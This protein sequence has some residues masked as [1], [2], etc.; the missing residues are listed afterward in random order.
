MKRSWSALVLAALI[1]TACSPT[2]SVGDPATTPAP[3]PTAPLPPTPTSV[4]ATPPPAIELVTFTT[5]D[6]VRLAATLYN[7][8]DIAV[9][10]AHQG[11][12]GA[13]Q[14]TW[15]PFAEYIAEKGFTALTLD[16]RGRGQSGGALQTNALIL[17]V[18]AAIQFLHERGYQRIVCIGDSMGGS[19]C[20]R[21]AVENDLAG[22]VVIA[23]PMS[24]GRPTDTQPADLAKLTLPKLFVCGEKDRFEF[25][26]E[27]VKQM[28]ELSP[29]PKQ[30]K[31]YEGAPGH[32]TELFSSTIGDEF[33]DLLVSFLE[34]LRTGQ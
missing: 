20:L 16:F 15:Q 34:G 13:D 22:L 32:G 5:R 26:L 21:A 11:T 23:S 4:P 3:T 7:A 18:N 2:P 10:L 1:A 29:E 33:R 17:D 8:G 24:L 27:Q 28:Y 6:D 14:R 9:I 19:A 31:I 30:L 25:V 12:P